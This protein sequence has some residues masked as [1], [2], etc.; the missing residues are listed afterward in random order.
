MA[1]AKKGA[2]HF[3]GS[4]GRFRARDRRKDPERDLG[5][6][7]SEGAELL[8]RQMAYAGTPIPEIE[9]LLLDLGVEHPDA[10]IRR[11]LREAGR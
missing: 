3:A 2:E 8:A 9:K 6:K 1:V 5:E 10:T 7:S 4:A 11:A